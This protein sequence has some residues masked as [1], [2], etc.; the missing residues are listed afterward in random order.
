MG[1]INC[2]DVFEKQ[3]IEAV[4]NL[5]TCTQVVPGNSNFVD[6]NSNCTSTYHLESQV[7]E[8]QNLGTTDGCEMESILTSNDSVL[9]KRFNDE[10]LIELSNFDNKESKL[11]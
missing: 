6:A 7:F 3:V 11:I 5:K 1:C 4:S 9:G 8:I 2:H 10:I